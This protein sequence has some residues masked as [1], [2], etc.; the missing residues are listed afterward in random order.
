MAN[1]NFG[2]LDGDP[3]TGGNFTIKT[4]HRSIARGRPILVETVVTS[5][6]IPPT[7]T[8]NHDGRA[9]EHDRH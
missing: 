6:R 4:S 8:L 5:H 7:Q 3:T 2:S 9:E 1:V